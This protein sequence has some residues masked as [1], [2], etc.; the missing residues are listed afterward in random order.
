MGQTLLWGIS[1]TRSAS[2]V[3]L[4]DNARCARALPEEALHSRHDSRRRDR[5]VVGR[6]PGRGRVGEPVDGRQHRIH[7]VHRF[8]HPHEHDVARR[9]PEGSFRRRHQILQDD[10]ARGESR[11]NPRVA[12]AQNWQW[13]VQPAWLETQTVLRPWPGM[14]TV[15]TAAPERSS[16][17]FVV[18]SAASARSVIRHAGMGALARTAAQASV[19]TRGMRSGSEAGTGLA[20]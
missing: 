8:A 6:Q 7:V 14:S 12:V 4:S 9:G 16:T 11:V 20:S 10:L 17:N 3:A 13:R 5:H 15:S 19:F 2:V 1:R 18:P